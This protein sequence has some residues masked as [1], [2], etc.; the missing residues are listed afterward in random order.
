LRK[1]TENANESSQLEV[2]K[3][4]GLEEYPKKQTVQ[5]LKVEDPKS[6]LSRIHEQIQQRKK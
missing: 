3:S 6:L 2:E 1:N 5:K 4:Q